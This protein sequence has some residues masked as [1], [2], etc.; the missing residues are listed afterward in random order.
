MNGIKK[1]EEVRQMRG[2]VYRGIIEGFAGSW[3]SGLAMI[4]ISGRLVH[5]DNAPTV[6]ALD[7]CF[8]NVITSAHTVNVKAIQ[9]KDIVYS[10]DG[11]VMSAF[12][13][14]RDWRQMHGRKNTPKIGGSL[15]ID[16]PTG[17]EE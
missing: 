14:T 5:C 9:G 1:R 10:Y 4:M 17:E 13:P 11:L 15:E 2:T 8:G 12:T 3:H 7:A 6:R 16:L